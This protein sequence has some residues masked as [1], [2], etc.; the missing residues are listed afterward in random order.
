MLRHLYYQRE[1]RPKYKM[2]PISQDK[3]MFKELDY[4]IIRFER[5][6]SGNIIAIEGIY[7][8]GFKD[9]TEKTK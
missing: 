7:G 4:F 3:F 8:N 9:R 1:G 5:D 6:D 2:I